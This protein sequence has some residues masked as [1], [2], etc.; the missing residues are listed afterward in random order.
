MNWIPEFYTIVDNL[1]LDDLLN[2]H[3]DVVDW[4]E[5]EEVLNEA[6]ENAEE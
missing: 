4:S 6:L 3:E 2:E 5:M 1:V